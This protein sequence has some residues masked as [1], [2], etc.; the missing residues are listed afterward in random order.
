[1]LQLTKND[2]GLV[3]ITPDLEFID[4]DNAPQFRTELLQALGSEQYVLIDLANV[5]FIDSS[6]IGVLA[7]AIRQVLKTKGHIKLCQ[8]NKSVKM[9]LELVRIHKLVEI[10]PDLDAGIRSFEFELRTKP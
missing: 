9:V 4:A 5:R 8:L 7:A 10:Y 6:G 3:V 1:M 2:S